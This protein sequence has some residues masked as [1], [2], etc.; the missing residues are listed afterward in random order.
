MPSCLFCSMQRSSRYVS[1]GRSGVTRYQPAVPAASWWPHKSG[2]PKE[3]VHLTLS[4]EQ[5]KEQG[6]ITVG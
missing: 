3:Y 6:N 4:V 2:H 1:G 5:D